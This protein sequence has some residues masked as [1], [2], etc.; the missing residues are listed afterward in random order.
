MAKPWI[1]TIV[2]LLAALLTVAGCASTMPPAPAQS[3]TDY[4]TLCH[5]VGK[6]QQ[7]PISKEEFVSAAKDKQQA[8]K[9][10]LMCQTKKDQILTQEEFDSLK[11]ELKQQ[12][13]RLV[14][15]R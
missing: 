13:I 3:K 9:V 4:N 10:F 1:A 5:F 2:I 7:A 15:P 8:E 6:K 14:T 12:V 11:P